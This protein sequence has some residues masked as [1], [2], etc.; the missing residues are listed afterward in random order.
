MSQQHDNS[1][2]VMMVFQIDCPFFCQY[3]SHHKL[4]TPET[5]GTTKGAVG[6]AFLYFSEYLSLK[7]SLGFSACIMIGEIGKSNESFIKAAKKM[8]NWHATLIEKRYW[9]LHISASIPGICVHIYQG[10]GTLSQPGNKPIYCISFDLALH[11]L[12]AQCKPD[13]SQLHCLCGA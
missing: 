1:W 10:N 8:M 9:C 3:P 7:F 12:L 11:A 6:W 2:Q 13:N 5:H 4:I